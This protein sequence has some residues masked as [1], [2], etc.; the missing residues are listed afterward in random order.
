MLSIAYFLLLL[1]LIVLSAYKVKKENRLLFEI[2]CGVCCLVFLFLDSFQNSLLDIYKF[3]FLVT[4]QSFYVLPILAYLSINYK[5]S[6]DLAAI[7]TLS[8]LAISNS[9]FT[10]IFIINIYLIAYVMLNGFD[11]RIGLGIILSSL[12]SISSNLSFLN[13]SFGFFSLIL[14]ALLFFVYEVKQDKIMYFI[15]LYYFKVLHFNEIGNINFLKILIAGFCIH[16]FLEYYLR[17]RERGFLGLTFFGF[18]LLTKPLL[19]PFEV[20]YLI[21]FLMSSRESSSVNIMKLIILSLLMFVSGSE[22]FLFQATLLVFLVMLNIDLNKIKTS[23]KLKDNDALYISSFILLLFRLK[24]NYQ[25]FNVY[26]LVTFFLYILILVL[27]Y[28]KS[29]EINLINHFVL[30][31]IQPMTHILDRK[32]RFSLPVFKATFIKERN[33]IESVRVLTM[34]TDLAHSVISIV[35]VGII[36]FLLF[37]FLLL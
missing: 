29:N 28:F 14:F 2:L 37:M 11:R 34:N 3:S 18:L 36:S 12:Y 31:N 6:T 16:A 1:F 26:G 17:I 20:F 32:Y 15:I 10:I 21:I 13:S 19:V 22:P 7:I 27:K 4:S 25:S 30:K 8:F 35:V 9:A 23:Y 33:F 24:T 5:K